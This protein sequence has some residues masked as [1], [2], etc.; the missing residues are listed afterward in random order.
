L[1]GHLVE[2]SPLRLNVG[3]Y[4]EKIKMLASINARYHHAVVG[5]GHCAPSALGVQ[6]PQCQGTMQGTAAVAAFMRLSMQQAMLDVDNHRSLLPLITEMVLQDDETLDEIEDLTKQG[7][8]DLAT[9]LFRRARMHSTVDCGQLT[10]DEVEW[11]G[12][13]DFKAAALRCERPVYVAR[14]WGAIEIHSPKRDVHVLTL[15]LSGSMIIPPT[16]LVVFMDTERCHY[17]ALALVD[18]AGGVIS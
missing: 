7:R 18:V 1:K 13:L 15:E 2:P 9:I 12:S 5:D 14:P 17:E 11:C 4:Y 10:M 6:M 8:A 16:A 3:D